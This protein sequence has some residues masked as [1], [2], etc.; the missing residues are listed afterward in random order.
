MPSARDAVLVKLG[1]RPLIPTE[2]S[3]IVVKVLE[4]PLL[5]KRDHGRQPDQVGRVVAREQARRRVDEIRE[6]VLLDVPGD[7]WELLGELVGKLEG[8]IEAGLEVGVERYRIG[9]AIG[10]GFLRD[11]H[12]HL[13]G[14]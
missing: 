7:I 14:N 13:H 10:H 3:G 8:Q 12:R 4:Q 9:P 11:G 5:G 1:H 2:S 6:L